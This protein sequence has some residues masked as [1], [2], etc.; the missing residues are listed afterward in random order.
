MRRVAKPSRPPRTEFKFVIQPRPIGP[1]RRPADYP[2][3]GPSKQVG[4]ANVSFVDLAKTD[5]SG[6]PG[7]G[8]KLRI[9]LPLGQPAPRS[10]PLVLV[11]PAGTPLIVGNEIDDGDYHD[12]TLP[13]AEAGMAVI[14]Y[15]LDGPLGDVDS[16]N[17]AQATA[18]ISQAYKQFRAANGG[19]ANARTAIE[20]ALAK[21]PQ[22]D[23]D[24]IY[25]AGHR[26]AGT[27]SLLLALQEPRIA[28]GIAYAPATDLDSRLQKLIYSPEYR[29]MLP[30]FRSFVD[31]NSPLNFAGNA[32]CP[33]FI[34][35]A[36]DD[37]NE[38]FATTQTFVNQLKRTSTKVTFSTVDQGDHYQPMIDQGIPRAIDW[39]NQQ[40]P[41]L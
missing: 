23:P 4:G 26:S 14:M 11:A 19:L 10:I 3:L 6:L 1:T 8:T 24:R 35:H 20:Y 29:D 36:K 16:M 17:D 18:A 31:Q 40:Q 2:D 32:R 13:Y 12:E 33:L 30:G 39:L 7:G 41:S 21:L 5:R 9:Y 34:F 38:P 27:I 22:V 25:C 28:A 37:S 15:S